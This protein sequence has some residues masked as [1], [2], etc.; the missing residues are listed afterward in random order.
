MTSQNEPATD[1]QI[2]PDPVRI[3]TLQDLQSALPMRQTEPVSIEAMDDGIRERMRRK[4]PSKWQ[5]SEP[6]ASIR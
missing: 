3:T 4:H 1:S 2:V 5:E 6:P